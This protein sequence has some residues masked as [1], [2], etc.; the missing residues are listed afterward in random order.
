MGASLIKRWKIE[1]YLVTLVEPL[2]DVVNI[3]IS[4]DIIE[5]MPGSI[6]RN[7]TYVLT[8]EPEVKSTPAYCSVI[9]CELNVRPFQL[10]GYFSVIV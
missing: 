9:D 2:S 1:H 3:Q 7:R 5:A 8:P 6:E 10:S 4:L